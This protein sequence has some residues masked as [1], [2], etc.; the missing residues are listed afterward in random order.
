MKTLLLMSTLA[1]A[2][3]TGTSAPSATLEVAPQ[4]LEGQECSV[5]GMTVREQPS[6]RGQVLHRDGTRLHFCSLGDLR[7][8]LEAP[9]AHGA[10]LG[11][12]VEAL[13]SDYDATKH[14]TA[15]QPLVPA[16]SATYV[17]GFERP[18]VMGRPTLAFS[19]PALAEAA[20]EKVG[21]HVVDWPKMTSTPSHQVPAP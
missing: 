13:P 3:C 9:S 7:A 6:P 18:R 17:V 21:G 2:A 14:D 15:L 8:H 4:A 1:L 12:W 16:E 5:C 19:E 10:V 20:A 11:T